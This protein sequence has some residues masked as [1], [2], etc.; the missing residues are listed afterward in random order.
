MS[1]NL[2]LKGNKVSYLNQFREC[3]VFRIPIYV[4]EHFMNIMSIS[5]IRIMDML[6]AKRSLLIDIAI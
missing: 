1:N 3:R 2:L 6:Q 4:Y 5:H